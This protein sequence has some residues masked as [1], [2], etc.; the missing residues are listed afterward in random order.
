MRELVEKLELIEKAQPKLN[1]Y[2]PG[3]L[4]GWT[5]YLL[6][7]YGLSDAADE[8]RRVSKVVSRAWQE[9]EK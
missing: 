8:V 2:D 9:R 3:S 1:K 5:V 4:L 7:K 6:E